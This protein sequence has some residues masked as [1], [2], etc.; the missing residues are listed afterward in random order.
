MCKYY[1]V[2]TIY[3]IYFFFF[4]MLS[5]IF[6]TELVILIRLMFLYK[7]FFLI[8]ESQILNFFSLLLVFYFNLI[9]KLVMT[10]LNLLMGYTVPFILFFAV[11]Q[12]SLGEHHLRILLAG[13]K[14]KVEIR[15]SSKRERM[16]RKCNDSA[17]FL[18][19]S[20]C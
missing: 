5:K 13:E 6:F 1:N 16:K 17:K 8:C 14:K 15:S 18:A 10:S 9:F 19:L 11:Y 7:N 2:N 3:F 12:L 20:L 4:T